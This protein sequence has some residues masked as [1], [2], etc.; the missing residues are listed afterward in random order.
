MH[1]SQIW[2]LYGT[3]LQYH[4][5]LFSN[6]AYGNGLQAHGKLLIPINMP[7]HGPCN[8][9]SCAPNFRGQLSDLHDRVT[10]LVFAVISRVKTERLRENV[11]CIKLSL[12]FSLFLKLLSLCILI[13][14]K[15]R[16][17]RKTPHIESILLMFLVFN[18]FLSLLSTPD[19]LTDETRRQTSRQTSRQT[20]A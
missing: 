16:K 19:T 3:H 4:S 2:S 7:I 10:V 13:H 6:A 11:Q 17:R 12:R 18:L 8:D 20:R 14:A 15:R 5:C 1:D 9:S